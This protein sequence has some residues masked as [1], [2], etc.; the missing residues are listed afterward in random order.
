MSGDVAM[1]LWQNIYFKK[2]EA[3]MRMAGLFDRCL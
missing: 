2:Y 3:N 1:I